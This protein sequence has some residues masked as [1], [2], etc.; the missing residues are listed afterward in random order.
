MYPI[1]KL[2]GLVPFFTGAPGQ[3]AGGSVKGEGVLGGGFILVK[4]FLNSRLLYYNLNYYNHPEK[5]F[6]NFFYII[7]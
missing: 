5:I 6:F 4:D 1:G 7:I 2:S 3:T